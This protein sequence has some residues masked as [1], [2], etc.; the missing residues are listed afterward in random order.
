MEIDGHLNMLLEELHQAA[1]T[2]GRNKSRHILD[3]DHICTQGS[4]LLCR[5]EELLVGE[6]G[7]GSL[8]TKELLKERRLGILGIYGVAHSA[9]GNTAITL[10]VLDG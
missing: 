4:H 6:Y 5:V 7:L 2:L 8:L 1:D 9:V 10:N 3:G